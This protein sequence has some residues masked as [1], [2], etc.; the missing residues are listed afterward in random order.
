M[1]TDTWRTR[2]KFE[3]IPDYLEPSYSW[4]RR[5]YPGRIPEPQYSAVLQLLSPEFLDRTLA[6]MIAVLDDRDYHVVLNDVDRAGG[7][8]LPEEELSFVRRLF[9][10][11]G[12]PNLP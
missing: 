11:Y 5:I 10:E 8:P 6:R 2:A 7:A 3:G 9:M 4:L 12:F 1:G